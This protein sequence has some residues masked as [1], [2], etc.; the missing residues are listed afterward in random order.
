M[1]I[2]TLGGTLIPS[3]DRGLA[4]TKAQKEHSEELQARIDESTQELM[5]VPKEAGKWK[6][7]AQNLTEQLREAE[8]GLK[9]AQN[10]SAEAVIKLRITAALA[11]ERRQAIEVYDRRFEEQSR[12][13]EELIDQLRDGKSTAEATAKLSTTELES[14]RKQ[15]YELNKVVTESSSKIARAEAQAEER[16][17]EALRLRSQMDSLLG[18]NKG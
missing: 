16:E 1:S 9:A 8:S 7:Q 5:A 6:E 18:A 3:Q 2:R 10:E 17:R 15:L 11:D 4:T 14:M 12:R 13:Y